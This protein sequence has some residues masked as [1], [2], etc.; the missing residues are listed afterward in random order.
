MPVASCSW[1]SVTGLSVT[2]R[3]DSTTV[4]TRSGDSRRLRWTIRSKGSNSTGC[5]SISAGSMSS[6]SASAGGEATDWTS[7]SLNGTAVPGR[8]SPGFSGVLTVV[9]LRG[10]ALECA[11][12]RRHPD[13]LLPLVLVHADQPQLHHLQQREEG[14]HH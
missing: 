6:S 13:I 5:S 8:S 9:D 10:P 1:S 3:S 4:R 14:D 2:K 7:A 11:G 12:L